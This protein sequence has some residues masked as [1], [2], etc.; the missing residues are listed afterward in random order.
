MMRILAFG[1]AVIVLV[2]MGLGFAAF[3]LYTA[4][5]PSLAPAL[6]AFV[7]AAVALLVAGLLAMPTPR[8]RPAA[9]TDD[10]AEALAELARSHP[11]TAVTLSTLIGAGRAARP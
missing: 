9:A 5:V 10:E 6:A 8:R 3:G 1:I 2:V 4:L 7:V 11:L